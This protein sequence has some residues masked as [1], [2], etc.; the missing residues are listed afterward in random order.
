[1]GGSHALLGFCPKGAYE[2]LPK[3]VESRSSI[4]DD[5]C[6]TSLCGVLVFYRVRRPPSAPSLLLVPFTHNSYTHTTLFVTHNYFADSQHCHTLS[7][8]QHCHAQLLHS[9]AHT[10]RTF[11]Q[12]CHTHTYKSLKHNIATNTHNSFTHTTLSHTQLF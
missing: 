3:F 7:H 8:T 4:R 1:M 2:L 12:H 10:H 9:H 11:T 6:P 5:S